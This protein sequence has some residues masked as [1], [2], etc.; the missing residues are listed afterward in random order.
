MI[1]LIKPISQ[2][3]SVASYNLGLQLHKAIIVFDKKIV[4]HDNNP[5]GIL[6]DLG[7]FISSLQLHRFIPPPSQKGYREEIG[8]ILDRAESPKEVPLQGKTT[9][10]TLGTA[11]KSQEA[12]LA[13]PLI[14]PKE[15]LVCTDWH[16][17]TVSA[18]LNEAGRIALSSSLDDD[19][20]L[21]RI[22][23]AKEELT[24]WERD[25]FAF[26][27]IADLPSAEQEVIRKF[28]PRAKNLRDTI[29]LVMTV[30]DLE[31]AAKE[32]KNLAFEYFKEQRRLTPPQMLK[33]LELSKAVGESKITLA[34]AEEKAHQYAE[35][36]K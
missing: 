2:N 15:C 7:S 13:K 32:A 22:E 10:Q 27:K 11:Q 20:V 1:Y 9:T 18:Q 14:S 26:N 31:K 23:D 34:E 24:G 25:D 4:N 33:L 29:Q 36:M 12:T 35:E 28:A 3:F 16:F 8:K 30:P 6:S 5:M 21:G 17:A 19:E